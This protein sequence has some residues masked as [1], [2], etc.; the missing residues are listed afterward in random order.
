MIE[1]QV[2]GKWSPQA[3]ACRVA[4]LIGTAQELNWGENGRGDEGNP[5]W[6]DKHDGKWQLNCGNDWWL[7]PIYPESSDQPPTYRLSYRYET[8][9]RAA[10]IEGLKPYL[11]W[12][13][14]KED[15]DR[16]LWKVTHLEFM[17][18]FKG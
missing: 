15:A 13:F 6:W 8:R 17:K 12:V 10:A 5:P 1:F 3:V 11:E 16:Q 2:H 9:G 4:L 18:L 14:G 7:R